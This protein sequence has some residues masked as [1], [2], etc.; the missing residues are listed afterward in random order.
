MHQRISSL[1]ISLLPSFLMLAI[2]RRRGL[3]SDCA[4]CL[5]TK[6]MWSDSTQDKI[7]IS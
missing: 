3:Y 4:V 2:V 6:G 1:L 5:K 7:L